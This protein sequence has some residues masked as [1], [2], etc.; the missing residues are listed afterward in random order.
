MKLS[1]EKT[2]DPGLA[3]NSAEETVLQTAR[4]LF[5]RVIF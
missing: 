3:G 1:G 5:A 4:R 2:D